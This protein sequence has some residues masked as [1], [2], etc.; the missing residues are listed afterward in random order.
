MLRNLIL[1][2]GVVII[3]VSCA[4]PDPGKIVFVSDRDGDRRTLEIYV[5]DPDGGDQTRLTNNLVTDNFPNASPDGKRIAFFSDRDP[6][7]SLYV[8]NIDGSDQSRL[9]DITIINSGVSVPISWSPDSQQ[10]LF[11]CNDGEVCAA[12]A[13]SKETLLLTDDLMSKAYPRWSPDGKFIAFSSL[14]QPYGVYVTNV[15]SSERRQLSTDEI[16]GRYPNWSPDSSKIVFEAGENDDL[17]IYVVNVDGTGLTRLTHPSPY[18][19]L[20]PIWSPDGKEIAFLSNRSGHGMGIYVMN[21][22]GSDVTLLTEDDIDEDW[23]GLSWSPWSPNS[24]QL[25]FQSHHQVCVIDSNGGEMNCLT[26]SNMGGNIFPI[27]SR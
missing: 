25:V 12:N 22:D 17:E 9:T 13:N 27:W 8:M 2:T 7:G 20:A 11:I 18:H 10:V 14:D 5:M 19:D 15:D 16:G 6:D 1:V 4:A 23:V 24:E 26:N 3:C 21:A